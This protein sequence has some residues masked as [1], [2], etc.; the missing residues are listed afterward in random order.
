[1]VVKQTSR[2]R[3]PDGTWSPDR[4]DARFVSRAR[5]LEFARPHVRRLAPG[6]V[7]GVVE[8]ES[9]GCWN[10]EDTDYDDKG[11]ARPVR[12]Y[13]LCMVNTYEQAEAEELNPELP[14]AGDILSPPV[15]VGVFVTLAERVLIWVANAA[16]MPVD[17]LPPDA[18]GYVA[19]AHNAGV[20][21]VLLSIR[22]YGLDWDE[23]KRR[24]EAEQNEYVCT[25]LVPY[26]EHALELA[27]AYPAMPAG[28]ALV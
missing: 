11:H 17:Q 19:W 24:N 18:L 27:A 26:A 14:R 4:A 15:N 6:F 20:R 21:D 16:K 25:R 28:T 22:R 10:Q 2:W 5:I 7:V 12:T 8:R 13:G 9:S 3:R 23:L 1:M